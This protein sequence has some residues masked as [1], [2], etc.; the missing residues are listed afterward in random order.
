MQDP[1]QTDTYPGINRL[2]FFLITLAVGFA[3]GFTFGF[4]GPESTATSIVSLFLIVGCL[5]ANVARLRNIGASQWWALLAFVP[6]VNLL[7]GVLVQSAQSGWSETR[8]LDRTGK[9]IAGLLAAF[10]VLIFGAIL[11]LFLTFSR[12]PYAPAL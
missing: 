1:T 4:A 11:M 10:Y 8:R 12:S 3:Y 6:V 2:Q 5:F 7:F 9:I